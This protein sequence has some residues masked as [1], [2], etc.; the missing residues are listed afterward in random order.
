MQLLTSQNTKIKRAT[1]RTINFGLP[2]LETCPNAGTCARG[3]YARQGTFR[4]TSTANAYA[5]RLEATKR[6][7]FE[8]RI[9]AEILALRPFAFRW[10]DSGDFYSLDYLKRV[11]AI[12]AATPHVKHY[13]YTKQIKLIK[14]NPPPPNFTMIFSYGGKQD[15][16]I[17][18]E[19]DR[20]AHIFSSESELAAASYVDASF[21]DS[22]AW[23]NQNHKIGLIYHGSKAKT[24]TTTNKPQQLTKESSQWESYALTA[25]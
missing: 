1:F 16:L 21:D 23:H 24:W 17:N 13:A 14:E 25:N 15:A 9:I 7:D 6:P 2:A 18:P 3:C 22:Q 12:A 5:K 19:L 10:H 20:H 11:Y 8:S 4:F